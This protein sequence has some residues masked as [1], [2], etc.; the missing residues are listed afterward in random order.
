MRNMSFAMTTEQARNRTKTITRRQG[1]WNAKPGQLIQQVV[2]GMGL[3]KGEKV[4][5]IH[6]IRLTSV[7]SE[8]VYEI[9]QEDVIKEGFPDWEPNDFIAFYCK[10]HKITPDEMCNRIKFEYV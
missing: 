6:V 10:A 8:H 4:E 5:K 7:R 3:K 9:T 1:W 2:K